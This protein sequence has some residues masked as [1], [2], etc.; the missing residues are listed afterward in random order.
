MADLLS[1]TFKFIQMNPTDLLIFLLFLNYIPLY[2]FLKGRKFNPVIFKIKQTSLIEFVIVLFCFLIGCGI[3]LISDLQVKKLNKNVLIY[4]K[5]FF[6]WEKPMFGK[7]GLNSGGMFGMFPQYLNQMGYK[8]TIDSVLSSDKLDSNSII[9]IINLNKAMPE[10]EKKILKEFVY[11][12]NSLLVMGDH[13]AVG[14]IMFPLNELLDFV[15]I[16]FKFD[17]AHYLKN[18]WKNSFEFHPNPIFS[19]VKDEKDIAISIGASLDFSPANARSLLDAK[20]GFSDRG[21]AANPQNAYLGDRKYNPGELLGDIT[22]I[23]EAEYGKGKI[24]VFGDTSPFQNGALCFSNI[25]VKNVFD[26]LCDEN[27]GWS[28][29]YIRGCVFCFFIIGFILLVFWGRTPFETTSVLW[30]SILIILTLLCHLF[31]TDYK[32]DNLLVRNFQKIAYIDASHVNH[33]TQYGEDGIW[34]LS[35]TLM[36]NN[37]LPYVYRQFLLESR[38][39][40]NIAFFISPTEKLSKKEVQLLADYVQNGGTIIWSVGFEEKAPSQN[41]LDKFGF[42][43]D[44]I[45]LG[46]IPDTET[47]VRSDASIHPLFYKAW[48]IICKA[49]ITDHSYDTICKGYNYPVIVSKIEGKGKFILIS[50]SEFLLSKNL[51]IEDKYSKENILFLRKLLESN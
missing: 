10:D 18:D 27:P 46:P 25:F 36:R 47:S 48:P 9:V 49:D 8:V 26:Y 15:N 31:L 35:Y 24:I 3:D 6:D 40:S 7:Y 44:N 19:N 28:N 22:L 30:I 42:D 32:N 50:D 20:Y 23:A 34:A 12:G 33:F 39:S 41:I 38:N 37:Y 16:K 21:N 17:C 13:T 51:E 5:G 2:F 11:R 4:N 45:P 1:V 29:L 14:G 43:I